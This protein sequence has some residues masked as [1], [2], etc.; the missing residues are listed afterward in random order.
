[1]PGHV[2]VALKVILVP[3]TCGDVGASVSTVPVQAMSWYE[4]LE[5]DSLLVGADVDLASN[6][7][8]YT[9]SGPPAFHTNEPL[10]RS[11]AP[12]TTNRPAAGS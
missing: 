6:S 7:S 11:P 5:L 8:P 3:G 12:R 10:L 4:V 1:V 9:P 2:D